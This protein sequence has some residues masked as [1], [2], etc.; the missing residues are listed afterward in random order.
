MF[1]VL[2]FDSN[3][4]CRVLKRGS[5]ICKVFMFYTLI[6]LN[7]CWGAGFMIYVLPSWCY[8]LLDICQ[9]APSVYIN[10]VYVLSFWGITIV[11]PEGF[12]F[13]DLCFM[14]DL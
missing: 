1:Y 6:F 7:P 14:F 13:Y 10:G 12:M 9:R 11:L 8:L 2:P 4:K 5:N 3:T